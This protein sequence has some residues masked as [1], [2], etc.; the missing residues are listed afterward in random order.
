MVLGTACLVLGVALPIACLQPTQITVRVETDMTCGQGEGEL[1]QVLV[2]VGGGESTSVS[3][4]SACTDGFVGSV[5]VVPG[6]TADT[7][8]IDVVG[9]LGGS[10]CTIGAAN[11]DGCVVAKRRLSFI[12]HIPLSITIR[13]E[14]DCA[15]VVCPGAQTCSAGVCVDPQCTSNCTDG[16]DGGG[17]PRITSLSSGGDSTCVITSTGDVFCWG[18]STSRKLFHDAP[19]QPTL[20]PELHGA[21]QIV[22][23]RAHGCATFPDN[24]LG[25]VVKCWGAN[26][27]YQAGGP[28]G[29]LVTTPT[30]INDP[31]GTA[32]NARAL[33]AGDDFTCAALPLG[34]VACWGAGD[35]GQ[36]GI[37]K[38]PGTP[39]PFTVGGVKIGVGPL[40]PPGPI[41]A[42]GSA[43]ACVVGSLATPCTGGTSGSN[44]GV[45]CWGLNGDGQCSLPA[46]S[47]AVPRYVA[48]SARGVYAGGNRSL[49]TTVSTKN[50]IDPELWAWGRGVGTIPSSDV[51]RQVTGFSSFLGVSAGID[52][53][54]VLDAGRPKCMSGD[55]T[56]MGTFASAVPTATLFGALASGFNHAC[57]LTAKTGNVWCWGKN[58][59]LQLGGNDKA[60]NPHKVTLP[61]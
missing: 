28:D 49:V 12:D 37:T 16:G 52:H 59:K 7:V 60:S 58:E 42:A 14:S 32:L 11:A 30:L 20:I 36:I 45:V 54:C 39:K 35:V 41:I 9:A 3:P 29:A 25:D 1:S 57:A 40:A 27:R 48:T 23:G 5:T 26:D 21:K 22:L 10:T 4:K 17:G 56:F 51:P 53:A 47:P 55:S 46:E 6:K 43:H 44:C 24:K 18:D 61:Q 19:I 38:N 13:L 33:A 31:N 50:G 15:G 34:P 8:D 2:G